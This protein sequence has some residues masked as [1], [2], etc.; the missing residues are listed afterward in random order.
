MD[1]HEETHD[2]GRIFEVVSSD[3]DEI[4]IVSFSYGN[5]EC[6]DLSPTSLYTIKGR[7]ASP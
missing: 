3:A 5:H 6:I 1:E 7:Y 2:D 4:S